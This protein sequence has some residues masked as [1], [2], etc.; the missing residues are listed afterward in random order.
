MEIVK[1]SRLSGVV[2]QGR[3]RD[4]VQIFRVV[5]LLFLIL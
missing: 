1:R 3:C 5:E 4:G 2:A